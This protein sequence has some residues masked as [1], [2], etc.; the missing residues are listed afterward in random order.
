[1]TKKFNS[2]LIIGMG[3]IGSSISRAL[4]ENHVANSVY[5]LDS[6]DKIIKK[7]HDLNLLVQGETNLKNFDLQFD[8]II[9]CTPLSAYKNIFSSLSDFIS[10]PTLITDVGST[11]MSTISDFKNAVTNTNITFVPSHPIAGL[12][13]SGPEYGFSKLF[14]NRY[15]ILTPYE[16]N[17]AA[18]SSISE[19]WK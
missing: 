4:V 3:L 13:K 15:C 12:E 19:M 11:K 7:C 8:L 16:T 10:Q 6:D 14:D 9:I 2:V 5:G 18:T 17:D 1:M